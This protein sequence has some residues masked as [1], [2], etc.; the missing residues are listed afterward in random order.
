M[1]LGSS[2][3]PI[4]PLTNA[5]CK[6][7][8][9][10]APFPSRFLYCPLLPPDRLCPFLSVSLSVDLW[11]RTGSLTMGS[12]PHG[13]QCWH[14]SLSCWQFMWVQSHHSHW[15]YSIA[16]FSRSVPIILS[17][18]IKLEWEQINYWLLHISKHLCIGSDWGILVSLF[19]IIYSF[20]MH[21]IFVFSCETWSGKIQPV[22]V[23]T[24]ALNH[25]SALIIASS[26]NPHT[27][28]FTVLSGPGCW[29]WSRW[30]SLLQF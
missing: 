22:I 28:P 4:H 1:L 3:P 14:S 2:A 20:V 11:R 23:V 21:P 12:F 6:P 13:L 19:F 8:P 30:A 26:S 17:S 27:S 10:P 15:W 29:L 16:A 5:A 25:P 18:I 7:L 24:V 9:E